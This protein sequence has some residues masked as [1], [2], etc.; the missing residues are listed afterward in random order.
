MADNRELTFGMG[1]GL[2]DAI[3]QLNDAIDRLEE[4]VDT[5]QEAEDA[6]V[7]MGANIQAGTSAA[8][9]GAREAADALGDLDDSTDDVGTGFRDMGR[10]SGQPVDGYSPQVGQ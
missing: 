8:A 4:I 2:D 5:A 1:F 10:E 6:A 9:E 7:G 3:G